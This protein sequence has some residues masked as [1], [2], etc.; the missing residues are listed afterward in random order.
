MKREVKIGIFGVA[1]ILLAWGGVRFLSGLD[2][3][4]RNVDYVADFC[5]AHLNG[6]IDIMREA[7]DL[8]RGRQGAAR[9]ANA[10]RNQKVSF[11]GLL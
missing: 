5:A 2:V 11:H 10:C 7:T 4:S 1:M 3:F 6:I 9:K 8:R